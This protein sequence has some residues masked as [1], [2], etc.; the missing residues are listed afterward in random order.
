MTRCRCLN[1]PTLCNHH[2]SSLI[3]CMR[4]LMLKGK[5]QPCKTNLVT[6]RLFGS[7][8]LRKTRNKKSL[9]NQLRCQR[10]YSRILLILMLQKI[11]K[12]KRMTYL[13]WNLTDRQES[14]KKKKISFRSL[15]FSKENLNKLK[16]SKVSRGDILRKEDQHGLQVVII[17]LRFKNKIKLSS[18]GNHNRIN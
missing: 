10:H 8:I 4:I 12:K 13:K 16:T 15:K 2:K 18:K 17:S 5:S 14:R 7:L 9:V 11:I 6:R 1:L 3:R